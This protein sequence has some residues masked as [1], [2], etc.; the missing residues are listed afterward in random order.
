MY[1]E[2]IVELLSNNCPSW[3][4]ESFV[5]GLCNIFGI[6]SWDQLPTYT[7]ESFEIRWGGGGGGGKKRNS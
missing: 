7:V 4:A 1:Y 5:S 3:N 2:R 6:N